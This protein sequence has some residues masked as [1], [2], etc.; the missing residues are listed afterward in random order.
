MKTT[1]P[2]K[3]F[4]NQPYLVDLNSAQRKAVEHVSGPLLVIAGAGTGKTACITRHITHQITTHAVKPQEILALTFTDKA[5]MEMEERVDMLTPYG[6]NDVSIHTFHAFGDQILREHGLEIGLPADFT[7][8]NV[9]ESM[10]FFCDHLFELPLSIYRPLGNP[11]RYAHA[12][13][14]LFSR[15]KDEDISSQEYLAFADDLVKKSAHQPQAEEDIL[16]AQQQSELAQTYAAYEDLKISQGYIDFGDQVTRTLQI[17]RTRPHILKK[18]QQKYK[19]ILVDEFQDTNYAQFELLRLVSARVRSLIAVGDDDQA[20]FKFRGAC[21]SNIL[22]FK[23]TYPNLAYVVFTENY[24]SSQTILNTAYRLIRHNDPDRLEMREGIDKK[25]HAQIPYGPA[26]QSFDFLNLTEEADWVADKIAELLKSQNYTF[27]DCAILVRANQ[28]AHAF[29]KALQYRGIPWY[30]SGNTGLYT[31]EEIRLLLSFLRIMADPDDSP[32]LYY[33]ANSTLYKINP[34]DIAL[35]NASAQKKSRSLW[36]MC[37]HEELFDAIGI[38]ASSQKAIAQ[39]TKDLQ[40][41]FSLTK[42]LSVG[43]LVYVFLKENGILRGLADIQ[44]IHD[45]LKAKNIA[46][47]FSIIRTFEEISQ[48]DRVSDF[49]RYIDS[50]IEA[51]DDPPTAEAEIDFDA[52]NVLTCHKSKGLEF[53]AVFMVC[54]VEGRF[55]TRKQGESIRMPDTLVKDIVFEGDYHIHEE[56]RLFYVGMT[57]AKE[58][59]FFSSAQ[60]YGGKRVPKQSR[61]VLEALDLPKRNQENSKQ[62]PYQQIELFAPPTAQQADTLILKPLSETEAVTLT[63][64]AIDD[65]LT[66]PLKYKYIHIIGIP[67]LKN[68]AIV[69]GSALHEAL[70]VFHTAQVNQ[71]AVSITELKRA[72]E[73]YWI[74]EGFISREHEELRKAA[75]RKAL[76]NYA[77]YAETQK[78]TILGIEEKFKFMIGHNRISGRWDLCI[79]DKGSISIIDF[80]SSEVHRQKDADAKARGNRQLCLYAL[81]YESKYNKLPDKLQLFFLGSNLIGSTEPSM[82]KLDKVKEEIAAVAQGIRCREFPATPGYQVCTYCAFQDICSKAGL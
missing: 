25:L 49:V 16:Y 13:L 23:K 1:S 61:F 41:Y 60:D 66:C 26:V 55:P 65:Y 63:P 48:Y 47:F 57:R 8:L 29:L 28:H 12:V 67:L 53:K 37:I 10:V 79:G 30:F 35:L 71:T 64:Y 9:S 7:V 76:E 27:K 19:I 43:K 44:T 22:N 18:Y 36:Y 74:S 75:G 59:L 70:R 6:F 72:F 39:F 69:Y 73:E 78:Y 68:H 21:L 2:K 45:E 14:A 42:E 5:A 31:R 58:Y 77:A 17:L 82:K 80:K 46:K 51:G 56:R 54:L 62:N 34:A 11:M 38:Q 81:G 20:I 24:R 32:S 50:L 40:H 15:L 3:T 4:E 52:V 33:L